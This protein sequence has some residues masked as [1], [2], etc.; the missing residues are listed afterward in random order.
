MLGGALPTVSV[1]A[2][3][4]D[5]LGH[6]NEL[7]GAAIT[8]ATERVGQPYTLSGPEPFAKRERGQRHLGGAKVGPG[9]LAEHLFVARVIQQV[10]DDL[11][12]E[13][14]LGAIAAERS[15]PRFVGLH[16]ERRTVAVKVLL[17]G[18]FASPAKVRRFEREV[19]LV[20]GLKHPSI[21]TVYDSGRL[22]DGQLYYAMEHIEG[23]TLDEFLRSRHRVENGRAGPGDDQ[24]WTSARSLELFSRICSA[25][26]F[27]H[28]RGVMHRDL[29][30]ANILVDA[31][32]DP[33]VLDFGLAKAATGRPETVPLTL[34]HEFMGTLAYASPEQV[35]G[36]PQGVDTR[37]DVYSLGVVLYEMLAGRS[38]YPSTDRIAELLH[39]I[40]DVA[41]RPPSSVSRPAGANAGRT[42]ALAR[43]DADLDTIVLKA[44]AKDR[45]RRY[46]SAGELARDVERYLAGEPIDARRDSSWYVLRKTVARHRLGVGVAAAFL[47]TIVASTVAMATLWRK[48]VRA[49]ARE[50]TEAEDARQAADFLVD[51]FGAADPYEA[52]G[53][54]LRARELLARGVERI[55]DLQHQPEIRIRL[56]ERMDSRTRTSDCTTRPHRS[57]NAPWPSRRST[58]ATI[59]S[60]PPTRSSAPRKCS[61]SPR[62]ERASSCCAKPSPSSA[63]GSART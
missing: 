13:P 14:Q 10:V 51:L 60:R 8:V 17:E 63:D 50:R 39:A 35:R 38:P 47:V 29:K 4:A 37:T 32:G 15:D 28:Q 23:E 31:D 9:P 42:R 11:E 1:D 49:A 27:A 55:D 3:L 26:H 45:E 58:M 43:I 21:V 24:A 12:G 34:T 18:S 59:P 57:S 33:H 20:A 25:V 36:D 48:S 19:E 52:Q 61:A 56:L 2:V 62:K 7:F 5:L 22:P 54:D 6:P 44:L 41:P 16:R 53:E 30:P 40:T 46:Q